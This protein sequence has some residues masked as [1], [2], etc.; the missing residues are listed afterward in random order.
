M[1][2][3][4]PTD[5]SAYVEHP[6]LEEAVDVDEHGPAFKPPPDPEADDE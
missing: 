6:D 4:Q 3:Q 1:S 5:E 2:E